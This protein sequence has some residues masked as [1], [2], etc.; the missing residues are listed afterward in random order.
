MKMDDSQLKAIVGAEIDSA[1][2]FVDEEL[3]GV[4]ALCTRYYQGE[5]PDVESEEGRSRM[6]SRDVRDVVQ[7]M[8]PSIMRVFFSSDRVVEFTP[9]GPEDEAIAEQA[10][11]YVQHVILGADNDFFQTF[12]AVA[13]DALI[14]KAGFVKVWWDEKESTSTQ[15][16]TGLDS[17]TLMLLQNEPDTEVEVT[18]TTFI[19]Q[20]ATDPVTGLQMPVQVPMYDCTI[21][22]KQK[23]GKVKVCEVPPEEVLVARRDTKLGESFIAHRRLMT[24]SDLVAMGYDREEIESHTTE[25]GLDDNELYLARTD[26]R[27]YD[28]QEAAINEAMRQVLYVEAYCYIDRN[29]DGIAEML[30]VCTVGSGYH[31][32]SVEDVDYHPF[33]AFTIDPEPHLNA[34]EAT[35]VADDLLD[36]QRVKSV[37]WRNSLDSLAQSIN[38]R[39]AFVEGQV[40]VDDLLNNEVGALIRMKNPQAVMPMVTPDTS[41]AGLQMLGYIDSVKEDRTGIS[42]SSM[43]LD[44]EALRNT[45]AT[46]ASAQMTAAQSRIELITR[47][48]ANGMQELFRLVFKLITVHQDKPRTTRLR[49][50]WVTIDPRYWSSSMDVSISVGLGGGTQ[51]EKFNVLAGLAQK[52]ELILQSLGPQN[53]LVSLSQ[54]S[55][56][57]SKMVELAGFRNA[58]QF[59]TQLPADFQMPEQPPQPDPQAQAAEM[60]AQVEREKAQMK[61]QVDSAKHQADMQIAAAKLDLERQKMQA[62]MARKQLE[63]EMQEQKI[64][65]E[66]R[67][68]EAEIVLKQLTGMK[69]QQDAV[70]QSNEEGYAEEEA[71]ASEAQKE[72]MMAQAIAMLGQLIQQGNQG[73]TAAMRQPKQVIRDQTGRVVGVAPMP[74]TSGEFQ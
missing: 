4:R 46:A 57:L 61:L 26:Y 23:Q 13:K 19:E 17:D 30:K 33:V 66:L 32:L 53:P 44:A 60:L 9:T 5:L 52:Q 8:L 54:Y 1:I 49:N 55:N 67:M 31:I 74:P 28:G 34:L 18:G 39:T 3:S 50:E 65:A 25:E 6:V 47:H 45:T 40:N 72:G 14:T 48:L 41:G 63:L 69:G 29:D 15:R 73:V 37:V 22:R 10:T 27:R 11:D 21:T 36:I 24:V 12:Y 42:K 68:K 70:R 62:E 51:N 43:G 64:L 56:T 7:S 71:D 16:Y 2:Y 59:V 20:A 35:S 58:Q 38:P